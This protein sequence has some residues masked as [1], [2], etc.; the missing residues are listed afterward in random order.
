[1]S[2]SALPLVNH[3]IVSQRRRV[4]TTAA[5]VSALAFGI[6]WML[7]RDG[8]G[9]QPAGADGASATSVSAQPGATLQAFDDDQLSSATP[10]SPPWTSVD[11]NV[12]PRVAALGIRIVAVR[13]GHVIELDTIAG[14]LAQSA[15]ETQY[16]EV[17]EIDAGRDWILVRRPD[18]SFS[19]L[20]RGTDTPVPIRTGYAGEVFK[21]PGTD[22]FWRVISPSESLAPSRVVELGHDG[23]ETG[24]AFGFGGPA[25]AVG[26]DPAGGVIVV[27][28]GGAYH[29]GTDGSRR[30]T[31]GD[32]VAISP[33]SALVTECSDN[34]TVCGLV[35]LDRRT[36][37]TRPLE[38]ELPVGNPALQIYESGASYGQPSLL[39]AVSPD[40]RYAP[41][42]VNGSRLRFGVIDLMTGEF[43][44]LGVTPQSGLWWAPD[45]RSVMYVFNEHLRVDDIDNRIAFDV[46]PGLQVSAFAVRP[47]A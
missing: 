35:V 20:F 14:R 42:V 41:I 45:S 38:P 27:A 19:Q 33:T 6:G 24:V 40:G 26:A 16:D 9:R 34:L 8:S 7:G 36:G 18:L 11:V 21:Q 1:M 28:P 15:T 13:A 46:V 30:I 25:R 31:T 3:M 32:I 47:A 2:P 39:S 22:R 12:D 5:V 37:V 43:S 29:A 23:R 10:V 4:M 44:P 17:P